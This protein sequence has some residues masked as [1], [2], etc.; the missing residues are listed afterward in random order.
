MLMMNVLTMTKTK[1]VEQCED[2][3][4]STLWFDAVNANDVNTIE[5]LIQQQADV[6][7]LEVCSISTARRS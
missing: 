7:S 2:S 5:S 3:S 1:D 4:S 6:N